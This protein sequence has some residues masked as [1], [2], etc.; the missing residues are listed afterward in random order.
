VPHRSPARGLRKTNRLGESSADICARVESAW[1]RQRVR[2]AEAVNVV[3]NSD[4][5]EAPSM[6]VAEVRQFCKLDETSESLVRAAMSQLQLS[7]RAYHRILKL[8]RTIADLAGSDA[9]Q[10]VHLAE[11][12]QYRPK[13]MMG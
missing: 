13:L 5:R 6:R 8:S 3:S 4:M 2:F 12:L 11:A 1:E 9:I 7:A 10:S